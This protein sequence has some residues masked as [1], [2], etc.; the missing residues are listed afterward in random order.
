VVVEKSLQAEMSG[1]DKIIHVECLIKQGADPRYPP[2][3][4]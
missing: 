4:K 2:E 1:Q 3:E